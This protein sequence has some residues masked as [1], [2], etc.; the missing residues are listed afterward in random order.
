MNQRTVRSLSVVTAVLISAAIAAPGFASEDP[1]RHKRTVA[2]MLAGLASPEGIEALDEVFADDF[3][4]HLPAG[5]AGWEAMKG[6]ALAFAAAIPDARYAP[7]LMLAADDRVALRYELT[8]TFTGSLSGMEPNGGP[9]ALTSNAILTFDD[10]GRITS[11][12]ESYDNLVLMT[13]MGVFPAPDLS[14]APTVGAIDPATW[15]IVDTPSDFTAALQERLMTA[16]AAAYGAGQVDALD[17]AY[18]T[19]FISYPTGTDLGQTKLDIAALHAAIPDL[20]ITMD[21]SVAEGDWVAYQ[22][23]ASGTFT[24]PLDTMGMQ[25]QPTGQPVSYG[26][27]TFAVANEDGL[28]RAEWNEVDNLSVGTQFGMLPPAGE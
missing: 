23:A 15:T 19:D 11:F 13:Q 27:I 25:L 10:E 17:D 24:E 21:T 22:W 28:V 5:D 26:G 9:I 8:G 6:G 14:T 2:A 3:V 12:A 16:N 4:V 7:V 18:A 1:D 20:A